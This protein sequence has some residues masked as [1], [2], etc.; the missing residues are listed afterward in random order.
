MAYPL[1]SDRSIALL[2]E[3]VRN[4]GITIMLCLL[5][6]V[7]YLA[8]MLYLPEQRQSI[9]ES[10]G[11]K[12]HLDYG[13]LTAVFVHARFQHIMG[14]SIGILGL[15]AWLENNSSKT[16]Y[17]ISIFVCTIGAWLFYILRS[18]EKVAIGSSG[19][20]YGL[21]G[22]F[23]SSQF[24]ALSVIFFLLGVLWLGYVWIQPIPT[25]Q[26]VHAA[27]YFFGCLI[28]IIWVAVK[29]K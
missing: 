23:L 17:L 14:N 1:S 9:I 4:S 21:A 19:L 10:L 20:V 22:M 28:N 15:G 27:G 5:F 13:L 7:F 25:G 26:D 18:P 12:D 11:V 3:Y 6:V 8:I 29:K 2:K 24:K 16:R